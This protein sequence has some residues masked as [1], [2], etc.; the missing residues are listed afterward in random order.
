MIE[1]PLTLGRGFEPCTEYRTDIFIHMEK[2]KTRMLC[3]VVH[4]LCEDDVPAVD[5]D[6]RCRVN[7]C[8]VE[9]YQHFY[10]DCVEHKGQPVPDE[11]IAVEG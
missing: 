4:V 9:W 7:A 11:P 3:V 8:R 1:A 2:C 6:C 10:R 5:V